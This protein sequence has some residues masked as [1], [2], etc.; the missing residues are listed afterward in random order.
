MPLSLTHPPR[1][2]PSRSSS[3]PVAQIIQRIPAA[4]ALRERADNDLSQNTRAIRRGL[5]GACGAHI[6][7]S[8]PSPIYRPTAT[9]L[10]TRIHFLNL[11][12]GSGHDKS[13]RT[14]HPDA[15][16]YRS[17]PLH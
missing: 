10:Y 16:L 13:A 8:R 12:I 4:D 3:V 14:F 7:T 1:L 15:N 17:R 6:N 5:S 11:I 9:P 2:Q